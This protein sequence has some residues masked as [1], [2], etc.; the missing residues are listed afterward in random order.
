MNSKSLEYEDVLYFLPP[1]PPH[2]MYP[3]VSSYGI[4]DGSRPS[5]ILIFERW[6]LSDDWLMWDIDILLI[7]KKDSKSVTLTSRSVRRWGLGMEQ[8]KILAQYLTSGIVSTRSIQRFKRY[9]ILKTF[10]QKLQRKISKSVTLTARLV[11]GWGWCS[12]IF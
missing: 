1:A 6:I 10:N 3:G 8:R 5:K 7:M 12:I 4:W 9:P 11:R 2:G